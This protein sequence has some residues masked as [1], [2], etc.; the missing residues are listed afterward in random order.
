MTHLRHET[1]RNG[2]RIR[3]M[4]CLT[5]DGHASGT[6]HLPSVDCKRCLLVHALMESGMPHHD[7]VNA[8]LDGTGTKATVGNHRSPFGPGA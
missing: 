7:A 3:R 8:M 6:D 2:V 4:L 1:R 5:G